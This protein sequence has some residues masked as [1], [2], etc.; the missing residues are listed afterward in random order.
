MSRLK[1]LA[2]VIVGAAVAVL[3]IG[4]WESPE[5]DWA[6]FIRAWGLIGGEL[7]RLREDPF[8]V[9]GI[10]VLLVG[11]WVIYTGVRRLVKG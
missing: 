3:G 6:G 1:G 7:A 10:L 8:A 2:F 5:I 9:L 4:M 11:L